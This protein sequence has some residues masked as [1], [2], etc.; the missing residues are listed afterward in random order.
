MTKEEISR[1]IQHI[2]DPAKIAMAIVKDRNGKLNAITL[3]WYMRTSIEPSMFAISIGHSRYSHECLESYRYFNLCFPSPAMLEAVK[4]CG[5]LSGREIDKFSE[6]RF[7]YF[8]G[9]LVKLPVIRNAAANFECEVISQLNSGDH[10]IYTGEIKYAWYNKN[11]RV[12][13]YTDLTESG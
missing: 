1:V 2:R 5:S 8:P 10:T 6:C 9:K 13:T 3:E 12:I 11:Q 4:I 7:D